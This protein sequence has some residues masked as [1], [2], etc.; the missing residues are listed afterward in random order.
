M[1]GAAWLRNNEPDNAIKDFDECIRVNPNDSTAFSSRGL[2]WIIKKNYDKAIGDYDEAIRLNPFDALAFTNRGLAWGSKKDWDKAIRDHDEAIRLDAS[3][4]K[5]FF[6]RATPGTLKRNTTRPFGTTT[7]LFAWIQ[8]TQRRSPAAASPGATKKTMTRRSVITMRPFAKTQKAPGRIWVEAWRGAVRKI[9]IKQSRIT[10]KLRDSIRK[11]HT[12]PSSAILRH[13][14]PRRTLSDFLPT[15]LRNWINRS[16]PSP[17][18]G[19]CAEIDEPALLK[20]ANDDDKRTEAHCYLG[21]DHMLKGHKKEA[22]ENFNLVKE[23]GSPSFI[24]FTIA[25]T[26]LERLQRRTRL[27][28]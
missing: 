22:V 15:L 19:I 12:L 11:W 6:C 2:A 16:G 23:H 17:S 10:T 24:E 5:A 18:S 27:A 8:G 3:D 28:S 20:L 14:R 7:R 1:H 25:V 13:T 21:L 4:G 26:E 9:T